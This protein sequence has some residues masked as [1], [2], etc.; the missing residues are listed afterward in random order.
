MGYMLGYITVSDE[1]KDDSSEAIAALKKAGV[2]HTV[3]LT[4]DQ[5]DEAQRVANA[6]KLDTYKAELLPGEKL[7]ALEQLMEGQEGGKVAFVGDG[8]NDAPVLARADVGIAMG[9]LGSDVAIET[10]DVVIMT[11]SPAKVP[12]AIRIG[13]RTRKIVYQNIVMAFVVKGIFILMGIWG[14]AGMWQA[15]FADVGV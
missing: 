14:L 12:Q 5:R 10:A 7:E 11:D 3:M 9:A 13:R 2:A 15:V 4:G 6:L 1:I 8:I